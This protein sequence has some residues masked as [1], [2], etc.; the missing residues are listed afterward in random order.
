MNMNHNKKVSVVIPTY[1]GADVLGRCIDSVLNQN[2]PNFEIIVVDDN[3][4]GT[5]NQKK[6]AEVLNRYK[7][8]EKVRY[9]C[10]HININGSAARNTGVK[11][12][13]GDYIALLDD[14]DVYLPDRIARQVQLLESLPPVIGAVYCSHET[15]LNGSKVGEEHASLSGNLL[16]E[17][18]AHHIE[19]ASSAIMIRKNV[20]DELGGFDESFKRHQ[21]WEFISRLLSKY[22]IKGDDF[23]GFKRN[24][25]F[26]NSRVS[27]EIVKERREYYL[28][29][30]Q[31]ILS[32]IPQKKANEIIIKEKF[33]VALA[34]FKAKQYKGFLKEIMS[35]GV[36]RTVFSLLI[37]RG[38]IFA[39]R[40]GRYIR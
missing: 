38:K 2:Y 17:Y 39:L 35:L 33:D 9:L 11:N 14:D 32:T 8:N 37:S 34:F 28:Q 5:E 15:F 21:D 40:R 10:H 23:Y 18:M 27:P 6:T 25:V 4:I 26:R 7:N 12:A 20:Y 22:E 36:N 30:M 1:D 3:G 19:I 31:P 29:K 13:I 16:Y 24:L